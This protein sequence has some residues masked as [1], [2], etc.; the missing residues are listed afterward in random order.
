MESDSNLAYTVV[1]ALDKFG[2]ECRHASDGNTGLT[3]FRALNPHLVLIDTDL[4]GIDGW[5]MCG[6]IRQTSTIPI[7]LISAELTEDIQLKSIRIGADECIMKPFAPK[8][9]M[10]RVATHLRRVYRY[11]RAGEETSTT[12]R[13]KSRPK[14]PPGWG[15]CDACG[16]MGPQYKF[17]SENSA[18]QRSK[19]CPNCNS[20]DQISFAI[21]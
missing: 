5:T 6:R 3:A 4:P 1:S 18:G 20:N 14:L 13:E 7:I 9:L 19:A 21:G 11:D 8:V 17:E 10:A 12:M 2:M 16:Y 15:S